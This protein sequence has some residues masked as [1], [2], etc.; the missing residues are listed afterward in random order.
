MAESGVES[1][2]LAGILSRHERVIRSYGA[3]FDRQHLAGAI[4]KEGPALGEGRGRHLLA[5][6][7]ADD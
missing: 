6:P 2:Q 7:L 1:R 4:G 5:K 3:V